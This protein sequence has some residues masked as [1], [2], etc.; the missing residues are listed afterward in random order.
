[1]LIMQIV[2]II[3]S[4]EERKPHDPIMRSKG[5]GDAAPNKITRVWV[6]TRP[7]CHFRKPP[8]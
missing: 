2:H 3:C 6:P 5:F 4:R 1:M 7:A 8:R